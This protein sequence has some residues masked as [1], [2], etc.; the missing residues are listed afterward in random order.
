MTNQLIYFADPMCSWCWGFAPVIKATQERFGDR[1]PVRL[2]LGGLRVGTTKPLDDKG[3]ASIREHW[4]HVEELTDQ[5]FD[6]G[7]FDRDGFVYDTEPA[8]RAV[9]AARRLSANAALPLLRR[10]HQAFYAENQDVTDSATLAAL[11]A[12]T[13]LSRDGFEAEWDA[14]DTRR[15]TATDFQITRDTG[16]RGY[17]AL[18][19]GGDE[20]GYSLV[21]LGY[22]PW[23]E[24]E[25]AIDSWLARAQVGP[26]PKVEQSVNKI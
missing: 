19:V 18:I 15:E 1:L 20:N 7:F 9:V 6:H 5:S 10:L 2:I 25:A 21:T 12:E 24:I 11:A 22:Q 4:Q 8:C 3:K 13:G 23:Q 17:P 26:T 16:I 14:E